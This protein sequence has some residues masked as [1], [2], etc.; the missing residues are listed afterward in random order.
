MFE[1]WLWE[2]HPIAKRMSQKGSKKIISSEI[3]KRGQ[4]AK[5]A[6]EANLNSYFQR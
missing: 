2:S 3:D 5:D 1:I 4:E 6:S